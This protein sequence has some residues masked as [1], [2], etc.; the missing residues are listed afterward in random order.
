M[1]ALPGPPAVQQAE[2]AP[3]APSVDTHALVVSEM[4]TVQ[5]SCA[6]AAIQALCWRNAAHQPHTAHP[7]LAG[8]PP[9]WLLHKAGA[10]LR[11]AGVRLRCGSCCSWRL[12]SPVTSCRARPLRTK[13]WSRASVFSQGCALLSCVCTLTPWPSLAH[14]ISEVFG[15]IVSWVGCG[16][17]ARPVYIT[18]SPCVAHL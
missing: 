9:L 13:R 17:Q 1:S 8:L 5:L 15:S 18:P 6:N 4:L 16:E 7:L 14:P 10:C 2:A 12:A 11:K 3:C